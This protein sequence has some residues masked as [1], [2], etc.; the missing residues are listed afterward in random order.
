LHHNLTKGTNLCSSV[1]NEKSRPNS[2]VNAQSSN[3]NG[4]K[5]EKK[6]ERERHM[7]AD[8]RTAF[9]E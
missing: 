9:Q 7:S 6:R 2:R 8:E 5:M 3:E 4:K 1:G